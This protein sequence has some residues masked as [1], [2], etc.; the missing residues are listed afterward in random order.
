MPSR[1]ADRLEHRA[2]R[3]GRPGPASTP[4]TSET[5]RKATAEHA[6]ARLSPRAR[7]SGRVLGD[8]RHAYWRSRASADDIARKKSTSRGPQRDAIESCIRTIEPVRTALMR[9]QP[10]RAATVEGF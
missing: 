5:S 2:E 8:G 10:G 1:A 6:Q 3:R 9:S 4:T 7:T